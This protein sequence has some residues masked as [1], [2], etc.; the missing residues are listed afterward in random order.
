MRLLVTRPEPDAARTAA[1]L[2]ARGHDVMLAPLLRVEPEAAADLGPGPWAGVLITSA[3][4]VRAV[5]AHPRQG[6]LL[7]LPLFA[8]GRRSAQAARAA[9]FADVMSADGDAGDLARLVTA[10]DRTLQTGVQARASVRLP[11]LYLAG[12]DRAG[13]LGGALAAHGVACETVVVYRAV[14]ATALPPDVKDALAAGQ[15]DG[16]LHYSGRSADAFVALALAALIDIKNLTVK[17][18]CV[19]AQAA[20]PLRDAGVAALAAATPDEA[21]LLALID[22]A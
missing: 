10:R 16:V 7:G 21:A 19:S 14:I 18:Y 6:E 4:A 1:A 3:N 22:A 15:I 20:A 2:R 12:E 9:G 17:H 13:D 5:A 8:V 11:L